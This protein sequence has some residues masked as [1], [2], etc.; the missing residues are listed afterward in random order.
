LEGKSLRSFQQ[1][2][3]TGKYKFLSAKTTTT[4]S[5]E[6]KAPV[7]ERSLQVPASGNLGSIALVSL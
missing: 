6:I 3:K 5:K 1:K 4:I 2:K 7:K